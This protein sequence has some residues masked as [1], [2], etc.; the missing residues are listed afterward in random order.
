LIYSENNLRSDFNYIATK[1]L[2]IGGLYSMNQR[3][4]SLKKPYTNN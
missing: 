2:I 1:F 4:N 3:V